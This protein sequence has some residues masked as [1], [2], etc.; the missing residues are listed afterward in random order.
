M[1]KN[2][3]ETIDLNKKLFVLN[4]SISLSRTGL[5][6]LSAIGSLNLQPKF[7]RAPEIRSYPQSGFSS[8]DCIISFSNSW[9]IAGLPSVFR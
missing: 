4:G 6:Y 1:K 3:E 2:E 5:I 9:L 7:N 8:A